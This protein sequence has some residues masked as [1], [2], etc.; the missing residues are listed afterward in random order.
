MIPLI[1]LVPPQVIDGQTLF[2][3]S[4]GYF[5]NKDSTR[6]AHSYTPNRRSHASKHKKAYPKMRHHG[7]R[8]CHYLMVCAFIRIPDFSKGE[9]IDHINGDTLN[10][11]IANLRIVDQS[12][13][14]RDGGFLRKLRNKHI[15]PTIYSAY[16]LLRFFNRMAKYKASHT[17]YRYSHLT[18]TDLLQLLVNPEYTVGDPTIAAGEERDK[19]V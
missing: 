5:M 18:R 16:Y 15:D 2:A 1:K 12:I 8:D 14:S 10:Y 17:H 11:S 9:V 3:H 7:N 6:L 13:N 4:F 19:Y